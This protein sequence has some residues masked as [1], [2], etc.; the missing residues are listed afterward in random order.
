[1]ISAVDQHQVRVGP[2]GGQGGVQ[3]DALSW[4]HELVGRSVDKQKRRGD[5]AVVARRSVARVKITLMSVQ[6][7]GDPQGSGFGGDCFSEG[8]DGGAL[9]WR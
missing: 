1:M 2:G 4:W 6:N 8:T 9:P 7:P 3:G 5:E